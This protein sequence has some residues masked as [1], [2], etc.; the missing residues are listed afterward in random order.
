MGWVDSESA[1]THH[2]NNL[3]VGRSRQTTSCSGPLAILRP[4]KLDCS[5]GMAQ[6]TEVV[7]SYTFRELLYCNMDH[8]LVFQ[9]PESDS[10]CRVDGILNLNGNSAAG[11][12]RGSSVV[13]RRSRTANSTVFRW[14][15]IIFG[16]QKFVV[17]MPKTYTGHD[18]S[19]YTAFASWRFFSNQFAYIGTKPLARTTDSQHDYCLDF[20]Q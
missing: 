5:A 11:L 20:S 12:R 17:G 1:S 19:A 16:V 3:A 18:M 10:S 9:E 15:P 6:A 8:S 2:F 7:R 4:T 13:S 14:H